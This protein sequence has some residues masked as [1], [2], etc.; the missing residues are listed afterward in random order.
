MLQSVKL[1]NLYAEC[2]L[3]KRNF[4]AE[5]YRP[6][7]CVQKLRIDSFFIFFVEEHQ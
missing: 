4:K 6:I 1:A 2:F 3:I 7:F 5:I